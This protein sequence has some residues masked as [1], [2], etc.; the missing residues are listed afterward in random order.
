MMPVNDDKMQKIITEIEKLKYGDKRDDALT[1]LSQQR[2]HFSELA[3]FIWHS[4]GTI[5]ALLQEIVSVYPLL[6]PPLLD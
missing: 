1:A 5:A 3:P 6:S 4:V 2:E